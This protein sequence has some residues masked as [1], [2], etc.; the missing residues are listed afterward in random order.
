[1][2]DAL[3]VAIDELDLALFDA[4]NANTAAGRRDSMA[5]RAYNAADAFDEGRTRAGVALVEG[6]LDR[7]DGIPVPP[8]WLLPSQQADALA[9]EV[10]LMLVLADLE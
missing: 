9:D 5:T 4:P 7:V 2:A 6:I 1:M 10:L 3:A 8:D